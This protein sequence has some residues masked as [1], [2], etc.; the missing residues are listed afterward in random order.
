MED[1]TLEIHFEL[2]EFLRGESQG[3]DQLLLTPE[4]PSHSG[5]KREA[6]NIDN[7]Q[8]RL[9]SLLVHLIFHVMVLNKA[10]T[11]ERMFRIIVKLSFHS[12]SR[13]IFR[14]QRG[15]I[16]YLKDLVLATCKS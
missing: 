8:I 13:Y 14:C 7:C 2:L 16:K 9:S 6:W 4:K 10:L 11:T 15:A 1:A 12:L 5:G 3:G